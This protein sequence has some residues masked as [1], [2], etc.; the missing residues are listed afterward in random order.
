MAY[1]VLQ[2]CA[3]GTAYLQNLDL[4]HAAKAAGVS[5]IA[6]PDAHQLLQAA[7]GAALGGADAAV[8][9]FWCR[10]D[11]PLKRGEIVE[12]LVEFDPSTSLSVGRLPRFTPTA[13]DF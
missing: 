1:K 6:A 5:T 13:A 9:G 12:G 4:D 8:T 10:P 3:D 11:S 7:F 2:A